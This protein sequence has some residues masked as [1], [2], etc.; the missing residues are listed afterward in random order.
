[1]KKGWNIMRLG[2]FC[3]FDITQGMH[4]GLP[5]VG[6]E[7]IESHTARFV[8]SPELLTVKSSTFKFTPEHI[9]YGRLRPYLNKL[10]APNF[11]GHCSTEHFPIKPS[12][13]IF[14]DYLLSWFLADETVERIDAIYR[15][16][17]AALEELKKALLHQAFSG[18][19]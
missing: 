17:L 13:K 7:N 4:R 5:Y 8:G 6:L 2:D 1:M 10:L 16:K 15:Q 9:L 3:E 18:E 11:Q 14:R 12:S 19:L